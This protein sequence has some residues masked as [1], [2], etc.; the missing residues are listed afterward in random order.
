MIKVTIATDGNKLSLRLEGHA[1][2]AEHGKDIVCAAAS[3]LAQTVAHT[4]SG[5]EKC[6]YLVSPAEIRLDSGDTIV[7]C[8]PSEDA[9]EA[10]AS[11]Y[12]FAATGYAL[13]AHNYP[14]YVRLMP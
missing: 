5:A 14:Q 10:I 2:Y 13:L 3:I 8:E 9:H 4:V 7:A 12:I 1:E 11:A 6:G